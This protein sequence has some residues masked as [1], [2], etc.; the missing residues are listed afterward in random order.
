[1]D[2]EEDAR[3]CARRLLDVVRGLW[4]HPE[5]RLY[6][7]VAQHDR[8][9]R[10]LAAAPGTE[11]VRARIEFRIATILQRRDRFAEAADRYEK[12][13]G[14][15]AASAATGL[16]TAVCHQRLA[17]LYHHELGDPAMAATHYKAAI[18][19]F[20]RHEPVSEGTQMNRVLCEQLLAAVRSL[21]RRPK[22]PQYQRNAP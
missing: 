3:E 16:D 17:G 9:L 13:R 6:L 5:S 21:G 18:A 10:R 1:V 14:L 12:A 22:R 15:F 8:E 7:L 20:R 11:T 19:L 4:G 2:G